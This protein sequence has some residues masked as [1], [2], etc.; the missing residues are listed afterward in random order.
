MDGLREFFVQVVTHKMLWESKQ[1]S[2]RYWAMPEFNKRGFLYVRMSDE[3]AGNHPNWQV[4]KMNGFTVPVIRPPGVDSFALEA[5]KSARINGLF[6]A[7]WEVPNKNPVED[8]IVFANRLND[9]VANLDNKQ[10]YVYA[11]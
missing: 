10:A 8:P 6:P 2:T 4:M 9:I 1:L 7:L 11:I 3:Y 5:I